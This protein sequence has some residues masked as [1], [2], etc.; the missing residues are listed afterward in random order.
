MRDVRRLPFASPSGDRPPPVSS[1]GPSSRRPPALR[2]SSLRQNLPPPSP[3][4]PFS[5]RRSGSVP[6]G[7]P[8]V[9]PARS[10]LGAP[11]PHAGLATPE[12]FAPGAV[13]AAMRAASADCLSA[14][15]S[16]EDDSTVERF[17]A[18]V[19]ADNAA[20][21][22][23]ATDARINDRATH[24]NA[25]RA[26]TNLWHSLHVEAATWRMLLAV[27]KTPDER[28]SDLTSSRL[29]PDFFDAQKIDANPGILKAQ[30]VARWLES[31]AAAELER[32]GGPRVKPLDDPAYRWKYS[33]ERL[34]E[35]ALSM[36]F[37][38]MGGKLEETELKAEER[39]CREL[40]R[41]V[42][43]GNLPEAESVCRA[44]GQPWRAAI[45]GGGKNCS[46]EAS[47]G[48]KGA[49][50]RLW[51]KTV[52][53]VATLEPSTLNPHE[54]ALYGILAGLKEPALSVVKD[55]ESH[56]WVRITSAI[57]D[58]CETALLG[59]GGDRGLVSDDDLL[60]MFR[61]CDC[62]DKGHKDI[63][64][65]AHEQIRA[66]RA[67]LS[68]GDT[69]SNA[70]LKE[71][72][73][74][75][76]KLAQTGFDR[77]L[78]WVCR[79]AAHICIF[80][81]RAAVL[82]DVVG[83]EAP[84]DNFERALA[85]YPRLVIEADIAD[86]ARAVEAGSILPARPLVYELSAQLLCELLGNAHIVTTYAELMFAALKADLRHEKAEDARVGVPTREVIDRRTLC[87][88]KAGQYFSRETLDEL[89]L[90]VV[91]LVWERHL[92][93]LG[94]FSAAAEVTD[95][96]EDDILSF[97]AIEFLLFPAYPNFEEA[98]LRA[99]AATR[100]FYI[101]GRFGA[102]RR[103]IEWF[104]STIPAHSEAG[105]ASFAMREFDAWRAYMNA[106]AA[107]AAWQSHFY[108]RRPLGLPAEVRAAATATP[109]S[110]SYE[111]QSAATVQL[112]NYASEMA[113]FSKSAD[114]LCATAVESLR[115]ALVFDGGWMLAAR[116]SWDAL[117]VDD[118]EQLAYLEHRAEE[119]NEIRRMAVPQVVVLLH[120]VLHESGHYADAVELAALVAD[121]GT[122]LYESYGKQELKALLKRVADSAVLLAD[123]NL[124]G[125][126][127]KRPY[128][129]MFFEE[130]A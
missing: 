42:R 56:A 36:D 74:A 6:P 67:Y 18:Q 119:I 93:Q 68:L 20:D 62:A 81:K 48:H 39:L 128:E 27:W 33:A 3:Y 65:E 83:E 126:D 71:L 17:L 107:H 73:A 95:V 124:K 30:R 98:V 2:P 85:A 61:E 23:T 26:A 38:S 8:E 55:Y 121:K 9:Q 112:E 24:P 123:G 1:R 13:D 35:N 82:E 10:T 19:L 58:A 7:T 47:N 16:F 14:L 28:A 99:T 44:V 96:S 54:K 49:A 129:G 77:R 29:A 79:L 120:N 40:F 12:G 106:I 21:Q 31:E 52:R 86:D 63:P 50:R 105:D 57:D 114:T 46:A 78:E 11:S 25:R 118:D 75:L 80:L 104:P 64:G 113:V 70:H 90:H 37:P 103:L 100:R 89:V 5:G 51:R 109:G 32:S 127:V 111:V 69:I 115:G 59:D 15:C 43:A 116:G 102:A 97:R 4:T 22:M 72:L 88:E 53:R 60:K 91:D 76:A 130:F 41:L 34:G 125:G 101:C 108:G 110:V 117:T 92:S 87:L 84:L 66:V 122:R 94:E 45:I